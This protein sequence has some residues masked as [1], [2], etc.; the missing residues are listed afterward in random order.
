MIL[1]KNGNIVRE[2]EIQ[3]KMSL[4][5]VGENIGRILSEDQIDDGNYEEVIDCTGRYIA[6]GLI[7]IHSDYI[8]SIISPRPSVMMDFEFAIKETERILIN[9]GI[10]TMYH[11]LSCYPDS[12]STKSLIRKPEYGQKLVE[13]INKIDDKPHIIRNRVHLRFEAT[14]M[15]Q[16]DSV[17][18][19]MEKG[20]IHHLSFMDHT[21]GQGQFHDFDVY[22]DYLKGYNPDKS[23]EEIEEIVEKRISMDKLKFDDIKEMAD[24]AHKLGITIASHDDDS[25]EKLDMNEELGIKVSEFPTTVEVA[26]EARNRGMQ[27]IAGAPNLLLGKSQSGNMSA[28]NGIEYGGISVIA[29]DYYPQSMLA[30]IFR[31]HN[32]KG[33][34]LNEMFNLVTINP[35][36]AVAID[37][38][39]GS[40]EEG[41]K[42]DILV[43]EEYSQDPII[44]QAMVDGQIVFR[45]SYRYDN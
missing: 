7:D 6:P 20:Y 43:I 35:A 1:L 4:E 8:E 31:V 10:T 19:M 27:T 9:C 22:R 13:E 5:I 16:K 36:R 30:S 11:S 39:L 44:K 40:I 2:D 24:L 41:K 29:S 3:E 34:P 12:E 14:S 21:P 18:E 37:D 17:M 38:R 26:K 15:K 42:A 25:I 32:E 28:E 45:T 23:D 33:Y